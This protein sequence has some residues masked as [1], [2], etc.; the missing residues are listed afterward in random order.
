M[1]QFWSMANPNI[2]KQKQ[3][4]QQADEKLIQYDGLNDGINI[5]VLTNLKQALLATDLAW[6]NTIF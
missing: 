4:A 5:I 2:N 6:H 1:L 3:Q